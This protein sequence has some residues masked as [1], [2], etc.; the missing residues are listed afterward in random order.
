M[1]LQALV[2]GFATHLRLEVGEF[3]RGLKRIHVIDALD[4]SE[5]AGTGSRSAAERNGHCSP[6]CPFYLCEKSQEQNT[7]FPSIS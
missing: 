7:L 3:Y 4:L 2:E 5:A 1:Q 6:V